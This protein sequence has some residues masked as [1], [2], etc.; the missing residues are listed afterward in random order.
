MKRFGRWLRKD[1][2][3]FPMLVALFSSSGLIS[4]ALGGILGP[5]NYASTISATAFVALL[6]L[7]F[8]Y[9]L[10]DPR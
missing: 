7:V 3:H 9:V 2:R 4:I 8:A 6:V 5:A 10:G 1:P